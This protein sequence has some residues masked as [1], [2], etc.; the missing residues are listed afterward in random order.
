MIQMPWFISYYYNDKDLWNHINWW[1]ISAGFDYRLYFFRGTSVIIFANIGHPGFFYVIK[2]VK[3]YHL[4]RR[5]AKVIFR[6]VIVKYFFYLILAICGFFTAPLNTPDLI[7]FRKNLVFNSDVFMYIAQ[8]SVVVILLMVTP[9]KYHSFRTSLLNLIYGNDEVSW[10]KYV[11][12]LKNRNLIITLPA[13]LAAT[14]IAFVYD[15][16]SNYLSIIGGFCG[17]FVAYLF[18]GNL[19]INKTNKPCSM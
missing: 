3:D 10:K 4:K 13:L 12:L 5:I 2:T 6:S 16:I 1:D 18:P 9:V 11:M 8:I 7:I 15:V 14:S 17:V 19:L